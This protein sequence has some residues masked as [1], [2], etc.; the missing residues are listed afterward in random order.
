MAIDMHTHLGQFL[1]DKKVSVEDIL[2]LLHN[3]KVDGA[4]VMPRK[5]LRSDYRN[6]RLENDSIKAFCDQ[7]PGHL[8]P[9]FSVNPFMGKEALKEIHRCREEV[10][11][12][13]LKLHPWLQG[14]SISSP[15]MTKVAELCEKLNVVIAF[16]DGTPPYSTPLQVARL[17]RDFP[18]LR[19]VSG[20][21]G[22]NDLWINAL[23]A[24]QRYPNYYICLSGPT[25]QAMQKIID[26]VSRFVWVQ[27]FL[28]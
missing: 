26:E 17:A 3:Q 7:A 22:L 27:I 13:I 4:L 2:S 10:G 16:H 9:A 6:H 11:I 28:N 21:A 15:E 19:V 8:Y 23:Q 1:N 24:A 12:R 20:H 5:G 18:N 25:M 14:F